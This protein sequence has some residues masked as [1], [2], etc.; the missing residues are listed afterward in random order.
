MG[1]WN[2]PGRANDCC[3]CTL[4]ENMFVWVWGIKRSNSCDGD[5]VIVEFVGCKKFVG[6]SND[7]NGSNV[8]GDEASVDVGQTEGCWI[9]YNYLD[10]SDKTN[11]QK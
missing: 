6:V 1:C 5:L 8:I 11:I 4:E 2:I 9:L 7:A 3:G 10:F